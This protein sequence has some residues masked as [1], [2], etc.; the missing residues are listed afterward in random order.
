MALIRT[1]SIPQTV[2]AEFITHPSSVLSDCVIGDIYI[3]FVS[4]TVTLTITG[5]DTVDS[6]TNTFILRATANT[7]SFSRDVISSAVHV[8]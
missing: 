8:G 3:A 7:I 6:N 2:T 5:A 1:G 4:S